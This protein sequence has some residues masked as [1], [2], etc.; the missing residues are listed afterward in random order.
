MIPQG[1]TLA[2]DPGTAQQP[3]KTYRIDPISQR[4]VGTIDGLESVKQT[5]S[6]ILQTERFEHLIFSSNY[7]AEVVDLQGKSEAYI[8]TELGRRIRTALLQDD[9]ILD[10]QNM[11]ISVNGD[12]ALAVFTVV[13]QFGSFEAQKGV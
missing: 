13:T 12:E 3:S 11:D 4:I 1:G 10:L 9:R 8:R 5:V 6:Q 2:N 7:G